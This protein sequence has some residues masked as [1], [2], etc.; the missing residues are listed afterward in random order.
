VC[1]TVARGVAWAGVSRGWKY[2]NRLRMRPRSFISGNKSIGFSLQF[3]R[4][5]WA[6]V[7]RGCWR[8]WLG[9]GGRAPRSPCAP[10]A[11]CSPQSLRP[12]DTSVQV[13][14]RA[15]NYCRDFRRKS[16]FCPLRYSV[17]KLGCLFIPDPGSASKNLSILTQKKLFLTSRKYDP[18]VHPGSGSWFFTHPGS[19]IRVK[20]ALDPGSAT[21]FLEKFF[22]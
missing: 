19:R 17:V 4:V 3:V 20:K 18:G 9:R 8:C 7:S 14:I 6:G 2:I 21:L 12:P 1:E 15:Q 22:L 10:T 16:K 5:A 13:F 11:Q